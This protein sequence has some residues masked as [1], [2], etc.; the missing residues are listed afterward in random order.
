MSEYTVEEGESIEINVVLAAAHGVTLER[1]V[2][3][4]VT[5]MSFG[6]AGIDYYYSCDWRLGSFIYSG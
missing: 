5:D 1:D 2:E 3:V 6:N 4:K